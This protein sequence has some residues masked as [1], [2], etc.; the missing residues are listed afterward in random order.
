MDNLIEKKLISGKIQCFENCWGEFHFC[1]RDICYRTFHYKAFV[2]AFFC[3]HERIWIRKT[4]KKR[5]GVH[6][7]LRFFRRFLLMQNTKKIMMYLS[8]LCKQTCAKNNC[9]YKIPWYQNILAMFW[10][11]LREKCRH[12]NLVQLW[13]KNF[14]YKSEQQNEQFYTFIFL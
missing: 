12:S 11:S 3:Q 1:W 2:S 5:G 6:I 13:S 9:L 8:F 7:I 10:C 14:Q 4:E